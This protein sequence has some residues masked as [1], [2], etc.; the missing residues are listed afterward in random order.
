MEIQ[1]SEQTSI[2]LVNKMPVTFL[3]ILTKTVS[4]KTG[5]AKSKVEL[6][7]KANDKQIRQ[8]TP[9]DAKAKLIIL[10]PLVAREYGARHDIP[11]NVIAEC[12]RLI[13][14][15][16]SHIS[17][18]EIREAYREWASGQLNV[19]GADTYGGEFNVSQM[20]KILT[21]YNEKRRVTL[22]EIIKTKDKHLI[23]HEAEQKKKVLQEKFEKEFPVQLLKAQKEFKDWREIPFWWYKSIVERNWIQFKQGE[24]QTIFEE[25]QQLAEMEIENMKSER[26]LKNL[27]EKMSM[28]I[29]EAEQLSKEIAR[30][31]TIFRKVIQDKNWKPI[32]K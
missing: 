4:N 1:K 30:K 6:I 21:A 27:H 13:M 10:I 31:L 23:E 20:G 3:P 15:K 18:E 2:L 14:N 8:M 11:K 9:L 12:I 29:P 28:I 17:I 5:V 19:Q 24:A 16:F 22:A 7:V 32:I 26:R 25:A